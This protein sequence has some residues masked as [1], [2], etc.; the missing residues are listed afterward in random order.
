MNKPHY[1]AAAAALLLSV[2]PSASY[3]EETGEA[4]FASI[5]AACHGDKGVGIEGLAPPLVDPALWQTLGDKAPLYIA[6]VMAGGMSGKIT[7]NGIDYIGLVMPTQAEHGAD[8][9]AAI[10]AYVLKD[11]N[12]LAAGPSTATVEA[13]LKTP[14]THKEL[15]A[16]RKGE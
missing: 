1:R 3:A 2:L 8:A 12:G 15:R 14:P 4:M 5:C 6:G 13:A 9:L 16:T 10:A 7:A 11:L